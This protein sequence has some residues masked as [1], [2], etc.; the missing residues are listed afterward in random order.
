M[1]LTSAV[2][3]TP[4]WLRQHSL[5][6]PT[7]WDPTLD[8]T[9]ATTKGFSTTDSPEWGWWL[10]RLLASWWRIFHCRINLHP[11]NSGHA[12]DGC[13]ISSLLLMKMW[14]CWK[15]VRRWGDTWLCYCLHLPWRHH[16]LW[17]DG[18]MSSK[19]LLWTTVNVCKY[20]LFSLGWRLLVL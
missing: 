16:V 5:W 1:L 3:L 12:C 15:R 11:E 18:V 13:T 19:T 6:N 9:S 17:E 4:C 2:C 14:G 7:Q 10:R 8:R 20:F